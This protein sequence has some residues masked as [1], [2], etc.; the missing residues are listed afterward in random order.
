MGRGG[1]RDGAGRPAL[2]PS[3]PKARRIGPVTMD[4]LA[5]VGLE[6][7]RQ[8]EADRRGVPVTS[9]GDSDAVRA[10]L[11]E[12]ARRKAADGG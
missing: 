1:E 8:L 2:N 4:E 12:V 11:H 3:R 10:A 5:E 9:V 6:A 7:A